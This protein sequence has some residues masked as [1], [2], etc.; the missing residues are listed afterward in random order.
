[1]QRRERGG[2]GGGA[3]T[4][5]GKAYAVMCQSTRFREGRQARRMAS[6]ERRAESPGVGWKVK[7]AGARGRGGG[8]D[9]NGG[10]V[11]SAG[12]EAY[13]IVC[14]HHQPGVERDGGRGERHWNCTRRRAQAQGRR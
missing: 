8:C 4:M 13:M 7:S 5:A 2:G 6:E 3:R 1:M 12:W 14:H 9:S 10:L 11:L